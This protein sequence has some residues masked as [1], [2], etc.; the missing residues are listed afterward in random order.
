M[1][2]G[3]DYGYGVYEVVDVDDESTAIVGEKIVVGDEL[4]EEV[5]S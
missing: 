3:E 2:Y 4:I 5:K 1:A